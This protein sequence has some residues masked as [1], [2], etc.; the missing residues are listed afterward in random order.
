LSADSSD[1]AVY[2]VIGDTQV[3]RRVCATLGDA[4]KG[5]VRHLV[6]PGDA[7]LSEALK[8]SVCSAAILIR[9]DVAALRYALALAHLAPSL[10][11]IAT[12]F[13]RTIASQLRT[14]RPQVTVLS[15]ASEAVPSLAGPCLSSELIASFTEDNQRVEIRETSDG[16]YCSER[17]VATPTATIRSR[18]LK[19]LRLDPRHHDAGTRLMLI[20]LI[21][22]GLVLLADWSWLFVI[23]G[24]SP[25]AAFVD[26]ARVVATVGPA[27]SD[28]SATYGTLSAI[29]MLVTIV[30][31][32][33]FTAGLVDRL[34]EP[35]LLRIVGSRA[36]PHGGH[37]IVVGMGQVGVR[38]CEALRAQGKSVVGVDR[39]RHAVG[40]RL[41]RRLGIPVV[42]G[43]GSERA[44]LERVRVSR[45]LALAAVGSNDLDNIAVAVATAAVSPSTRVVLRAGEQEAVAE[46]RSLLPLGAIRDVTKIGATFVVATMLGRNARAVVSDGHTVFLRTD[47]SE[48]VPFRV[49]PKEECLHEVARPAAAH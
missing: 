34:F 38:L 12:V 29:A 48:Y 16:R 23:E 27:A 45:C 24:H 44:L 46:T 5:S 2:L 35:R 49:S 33:L 13:D 18:L 17:A 15:P 36:L 30:L 47:G 11:L 41:A 7:E 25:D 3:A 21:G 14:F 6:A 19:A 26:A 43:D 39:D 32:A 37:V 9:D 4:F 20:G 1:S 28:V 31:T 40:V 10:P 8:E 22:L 42:I